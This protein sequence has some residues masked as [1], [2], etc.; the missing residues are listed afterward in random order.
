MKK[1]LL[2][3]APFSMLLFCCSNPTTAEDKS[4]AHDSTASFDLASVKATIMESN[5]AFSDAIIKGDS[6]TIANSYSSDANLLPPNMPK[7]E[8]PQQIMNMAA[9]FAKMGIKSFSLQSTN[10]YGGPDM[11][12]EEG[13]YTVGDGTGKTLDEGKYIV[14][15]KQ[16]NGKWKMFRDIWNSNMPPEKPA[17]KK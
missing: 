8:N 1:I 17:S 10:V 13:M 11:V 12:T 14:L 5:K 2:L 4:A 9:G 7:A 15:W 16:E 6:T 3:I